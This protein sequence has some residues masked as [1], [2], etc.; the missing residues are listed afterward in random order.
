MRCHSASFI[1]PQSWLSLSIQKYQEVKARVGAHVVRPC[2]KPKRRRR[3]RKRRAKRK[4]RRKRKREMM[5]MRWWQCRL[6]F[7]KTYFNKGFQMF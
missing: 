2:S 6:R 7:F 5:M 1:I 3:G 4:R